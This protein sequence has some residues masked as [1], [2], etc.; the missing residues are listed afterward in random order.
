MP[1]AL[2]ADERVLLTCLTRLSQERDDPVVS[3]RVQTRDSER[4]VTVVYQSGRLR[5]LSEYVYSTV[6]KETES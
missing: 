2:S 3:L 5:I 4:W 6:G 1:S